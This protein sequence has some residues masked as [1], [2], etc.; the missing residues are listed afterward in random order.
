MVLDD[1]VAEDVSQW[2]VSL[3]D[4]SA[5]IAGVFERVEPRRWARAYL[6]GLLAPVER[7]NS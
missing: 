6:L 5:R 3:D 2:R 4:V 1:V 7:K